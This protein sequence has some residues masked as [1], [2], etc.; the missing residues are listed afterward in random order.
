MIGAD[1]P[2]IVQSL[3]VAL[4]CVATKRDFDRTVA[5]HPTTAEE[6]VLRCG[7][8][9]RHPRRIPEHEDDPARFH[10]SGYGA[11][12]HQR[13]RGVACVRHRRATAGAH[14]HGNAA[15]RAGRRAAG[16]VDG[17]RTLAGRGRR[18]AIARQPAGPGGTAGKRPRP[19]RGPQRGRRA[20]GARS[21]PRA[22]AAQPDA[23]AAGRAAGAGFGNHRSS[24]RRRWP[25][26]CRPP[27]PHR[28]DLG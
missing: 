15:P 2:E 8:V 13:V 21:R 14:G 19:H 24:G 6:F 25:A 11:G 3:A 1:A 27:G 10:R 12:R 22:D 28:F 26:P 18:L 16:R 5:V 9:A 7:A 4:T 20:V 23:G 17:G